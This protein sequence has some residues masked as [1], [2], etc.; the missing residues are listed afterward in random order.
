MLGV[1]SDIHRVRTNP[2]DPMDVRNYPQQ[3]THPQAMFFKFSDVNL[4]SDFD[5]FWENLASTY[6]QHTKET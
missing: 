3:G 4:G 5:P 2:E 6:L 1:I